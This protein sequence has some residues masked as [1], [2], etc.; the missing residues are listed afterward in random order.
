MRGARS[1]RSRCSWRSAAIELR[2]PGAHGEFEIAPDSDNDRARLR[3]RCRRGMRELV[4]L[5]ILF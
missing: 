4:V 3:W 1:P 2:A 5:L